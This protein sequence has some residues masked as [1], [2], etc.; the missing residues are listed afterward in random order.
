[1]GDFWSSLIPSSCFLFYLFFA[2]LCFF[3]IS[4][5]LSHPQNLAHAASTITIKQTTRWRMYLLSKSWVIFIICMPS[6]P[7]RYQTF[8]QVLI[9]LGKERG[10]PRLSEAATLDSLPQFIPLVPKNRCIVS[11]HW[12]KPQTILWAPRMECRDLG[13]SNWFSWYSV[14][15]HNNQGCPLSCRGWL[16]F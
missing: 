4:L 12:N 6:Q 11:H 8:L 13:T 16:H 15:C 3:L 7:S 10:R 2:L 1:M 14:H 5:S 9:G